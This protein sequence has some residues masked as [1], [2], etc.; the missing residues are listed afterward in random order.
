MIKH[1]LKPIFNK[2]SRILIL[3]S[4]PSPKSREVG[5]YYGNPQNRMWKVLASIFDEEVPVDKKAF[6]LKHN[7]A[8]WDVLESCEIV[9]SADSTITHEVPNDLRLIL[10]NADIRLI[11]TAGNKA[12]QLYKKYNNYEIKHIALPSTSPANATWSLEKLVK[13]YSAIKL[14]I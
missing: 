5:M 1:P 12:T 14:H 2:K 6:L 13:A 8:M 10:D 7:I 11:V 4:F 3:G 9:G